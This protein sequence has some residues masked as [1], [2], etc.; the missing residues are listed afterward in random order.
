MPRRRRWSCRWRPSRTRGR[1]RS[2]F[3]WPS[4][5]AS[6]TRLSGRSCSTASSRNFS[7][8]HPSRGH[9]PAD[10]RSA[11]GRGFGPLV[12]SLVRSAGA[13]KIGSATPVIRARLQNAKGDQRRTLI[14]TLGQI[15][16]QDAIEI[17]TGMT[18]DAG[19]TAEDRAAAVVAL[20]G[21]AERRWRL[22]GNCSA[23]TRP[24]GARCSHR[25]PAGPGIHA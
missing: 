14:E 16:S 25:R 20:A 21:P 12:D 22:M 1:R 18:S 4:E 7:S 19:Y 2:W 5:D 8:Q 13:W 10:C 23:T 3:A 24:K 17:L 9:R 11:R 6:G 15:A